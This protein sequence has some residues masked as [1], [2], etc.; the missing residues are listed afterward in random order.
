MR[1]YGDDEQVRDGS[2]QRVFGPS[3]REDEFWSPRESDK[4][5]KATIERNRS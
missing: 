2:W 1:M 4:R 5:L 3:G